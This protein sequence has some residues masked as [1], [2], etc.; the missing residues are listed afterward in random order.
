LKGVQS[1]KC[2]KS[3]SILFLFEKI[4][5][6]EGST[7]PMDKDYT[8]KESHEKRIARKHYGIYLRDSIRTGKI[9]Y[10]KNQ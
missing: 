3:P 6:G 1:N 7:K 10:W 2:K 9:L 8:K 4:E 5:V